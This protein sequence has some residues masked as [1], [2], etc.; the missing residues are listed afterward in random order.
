[1]EKLA[2][3]LFSYIE[4]KEYRYKVEEGFYEGSANVYIYK[5]EEITHCKLFV[6]YKG[7]IMEEEV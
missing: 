1:M 7:S 5:K 6:M 3:E 2:I 4:N